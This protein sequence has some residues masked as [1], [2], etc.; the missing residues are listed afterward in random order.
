[1]HKLFS[2]PSVLLG[3]II[4]SCFYTLKS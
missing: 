4:L 2:G 3:V 1:M